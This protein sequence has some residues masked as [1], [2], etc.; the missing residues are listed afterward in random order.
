MDQIEKTS[1]GLDVDLACVLCYALGPVTGLAI[2]KLEKRDHL[3]HFHALQST[4]LLAPL[5]VFFPIF[6]LIPVGGSAAA[7]FVLYTLGGFIGIGTIALLAWIVPCAWRM[8]RKRAPIVG[9]I[10][11]RW[12]PDEGDAD[13]M[14]AAE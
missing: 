12:V 11:D 1:F 5:F 10:V 6:F 2:W 13:A 14:K 9:K 7:K 8:E 3:V 4:L